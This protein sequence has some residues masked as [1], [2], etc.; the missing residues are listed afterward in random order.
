LELT[1]PWHHSDRLIT[2]DAY[3]ASIEPALKLKEKDLLFIGNVKHCSRRFPK[4]VLG[5]V[6]L[7]KQG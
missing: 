2:G 5:N 7:P 1:E 4:E 3:F 6:T